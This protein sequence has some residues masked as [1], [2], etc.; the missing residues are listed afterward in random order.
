MRSKFEGEVHK[1]LLALQR[2][3]GFSHSYEP[4]SY[5]YIVE[6]WYTPDFRVERKDG[7]VFF[8]EAKG[9]W[10]AEDR[11]KLRHIKEQHEGIDIR[12]VFQRDNKIH[13]SSQTKYSDYCQKHGFTYAIGV[14]PEE[15]LSGS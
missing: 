3:H 11:R 12:L 4:E 5:S 2:K 15:W 7:S 6:H 14:I 8:I 10:D 13:R 9:Y 1:G